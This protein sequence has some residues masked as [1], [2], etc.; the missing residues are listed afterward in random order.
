MWMTYI[1]HAI[2]IW[3]VKMKCIPLP[4]SDTAPFELFDFGFVWV[5]E[6]SPTIFHNYYLL[7][8]KSN[9]FPIDSRT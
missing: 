7:I 1:K 3:H 4:V 2:T 8:I 5:D 6:D 9:D